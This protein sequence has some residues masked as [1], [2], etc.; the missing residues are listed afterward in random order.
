M[1]GNMQCVDGGLASSWSSIAGFCKTYPVC[2][3]LLCLNTVTYALQKYCQSQ[4]GFR[5]L[6]SRYDLDHKAVRRGQWWRL[7]TSIFLHKDFLHLA[8]N[9]CALFNTRN[10]ERFFGSAKYLALYLCSGLAGNL[11]SL[12]FNNRD[13]R[14]LGASGAI[15][16][17]EG[18]FLAGMLKRDER[19]AQGAAE[20]IARELALGILLSAGRV[21]PNVNHVAH[22]GGLVGGLSLGYLIS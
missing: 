16:G 21:I 2:T 14:S 5:T 20:N 19:L 17:I 22:L 8:L 11:A 1:Q 4:K 3:T 15:F 7:G 10:I 13:S 9:S 18:A 6:E 12:F